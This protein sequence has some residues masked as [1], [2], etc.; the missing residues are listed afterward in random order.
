M[1]QGDAENIGDQPHEFVPGA[2][3][4]IKGEQENQGGP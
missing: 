3:N 2:S 1:V 4:V